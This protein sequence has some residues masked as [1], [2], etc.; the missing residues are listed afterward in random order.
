MAA[1]ASV[2]N[3]ADA[4]MRWFYVLEDIAELENDENER[5]KILKCQDSLK[6]YPSTI[7]V[8]QIE[9]FAFF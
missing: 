2:A 6:K 1:V 5:Q 3:N 9:Y 7:Q 8:H 4:N